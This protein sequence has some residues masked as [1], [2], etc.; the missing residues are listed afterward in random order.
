VTVFLELPTANPGA[1]TA[2]V[3]HVVLS[4][5]TR[6]GFAKIVEDLA[7]NYEILVILACGFQNFAENT[8]LC[9]DM[10]NMS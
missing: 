10:R 4:R 2:I 1:I 6:L 8:D 7:K 3:D 5:P 9:F